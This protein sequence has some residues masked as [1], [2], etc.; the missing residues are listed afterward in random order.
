MDIMKN[1]LERLLFID[2]ESFKQECEKIR[3]SIELA[4]EADIS[5]CKL[6]AEL[7]VRIVI[8]IDQRI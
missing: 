5:I 4:V 7:N 3:E 1:Y 8:L 6:N 2:K